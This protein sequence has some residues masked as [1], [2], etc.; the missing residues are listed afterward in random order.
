MNLNE[1]SFVVVV[2]TNAYIQFDK[3]RKKQQEST[4]TVVDLT[5][6]MKYLC[7]QINASCRVD[8]IED[9]EFKVKCEKFLNN[10]Q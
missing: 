9:K 8:Q 1:S 2:G 4:S 3:S 6:K 10:V 7:L 5:D